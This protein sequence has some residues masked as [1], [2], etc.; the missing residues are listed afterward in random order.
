[1]PPHT[2]TRISP[3]APRLPHADIQ[4]STRAVT[5]TPAPRLRY[6]ARPQ[7]RDAP[8]KMMRDEDASTHAICLPLLEDMARQLSMKRWIYAEQLLPCTRSA[9]KSPKRR[10]SCFRFEKIRKIRK[11]CAK[12]RY[13]CAEGGGRIRAARADARGENIR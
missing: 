8:Q 1:M 10:L 6:A 2:F 13:V 11:R 9:R 7:R 5:E 3:L 4:N 12:K